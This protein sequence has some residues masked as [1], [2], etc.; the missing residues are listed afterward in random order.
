MFL[1]QLN[2][3]VPH[4]PKSK[5]FT[6]PMLF[7]WFKEITLRWQVYSFFFMNYSYVAVGMKVYCW[8]KFQ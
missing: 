3:N 1:S 5:H 2:E 4:P 7:Q 6:M 8:H